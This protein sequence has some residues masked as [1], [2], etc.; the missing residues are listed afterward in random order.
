MTRRLLS[1]AALAITTIAIAAP[2]AQ[3]RDLEPGEAEWV[4]T[5][6]DLS[7]PTG[8]V[9]DVSDNAQGPTIPSGCSNVNSGRISSGR[10]SLS[11]ILGEIDYSNGTTW[12]S[13]VWTYRTPDA[14]R[15]SFA[16][17]QSSSL[18]LCNDSFTGLIGDDV[19]DMPAVLVDRAKK[20]PGATQPRFAVATSQ[21]LTQ[22]ATAR[23]GYTNE[24]SYAVFTVVD[25][26][27]VQVNVFQPKPVTT[28]QRADAGRAATSVA[29]RY[30][31]SR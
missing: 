20:V 29:K 6:D 15:A 22:P 5:T 10:N 30:A 9:T 12:Q 21:V 23:P 2:A 27:I 8:K 31:A 19:A 17:L 18:V 7:S 4:I 24:F 3:A 1:I 13:S 16:K 28:A 25:D 26:A 11:T 14:A